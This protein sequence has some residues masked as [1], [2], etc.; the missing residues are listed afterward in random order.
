MLRKRTKQQFLKCWR[1]KYK[2]GHKKLHVPTLSSKVRPP[3]FGLSPKLLYIQLEEKT[4]ID[5]D[6]DG[7]SKKSVSDLLIQHELSERGNNKYNSSCSNVQLEVVTKGRRNESLSMMKQTH[8]S[9]L[10]FLVVEEEQG[11]FQ[12]GMDTSINYLVMSQQKDNLSTRKKSKCYKYWHFKYKIKRNNVF[13]LAVGLIYAVM[14]HD[15]RD[16]PTAAT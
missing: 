13:G 11:L 3:G 1:F 12:R 2:R 15:S 16:E 14:G 4:R 10:I 9:M 6:V 5:K 8:M 7:V